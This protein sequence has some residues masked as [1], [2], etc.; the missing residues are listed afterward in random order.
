MK[1]TDLN[2]EVGGRI[3][4]I[5]EYSNLTREVLA[6]KA[7][8]SVQ[9]LADIENGRKSMTVKTLKKLSESLM[10]SSDYIVFGSPSS[11]SDQN[12]N[13]ESPLYNMLEMLTPRQREDAEELLKIYI[14]A[15]HSDQ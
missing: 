9:F 8:I 5:R 14:R 11:S 15:V 6:E 1:N 7:D 2:K 12:R 4:M 3:R 10:V 13:D